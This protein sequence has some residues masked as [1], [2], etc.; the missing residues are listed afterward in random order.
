[1]DRK[2]ILI[3]L[4]MAVF[5]FPVNDSFVSAKSCKNQK[6]DLRGQKKD[7]IRSLCEDILQSFKSRS[8]FSASDGIFGLMDTC[9]KSD[10]SVKTNPKGNCGKQKNHIRKRYN[11]KI[12]S[13]QQFSCAAKA[14]SDYGK[15]ECYISK[16]NARDDLQGTIAQVATISEGVVARNKIKGGFT[17]EVITCVDGVRT[18]GHWVCDSSAVTSVAEYQACKVTCN[19]DQVIDERARCEAKCSQ[20]LDACKLVGN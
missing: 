6:S 10:W 15:D 17:R 19:A 18:K 4:L 20:E 11:E 16:G 2:F 5:V 7:I 13:L 12:D 8:F 14:C 3:G 1:M 9:E